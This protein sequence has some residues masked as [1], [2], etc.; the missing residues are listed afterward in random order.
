VVLGALIPF[1]VV[2]ANVVF[3]V[4]LGGELF[5]APG[6]RALVGLLAR[7]NALMGLQVALLGERLLTARMRTPERPLPGLRQSWPR[8]VGA[9]MDLE[10]ANAGVLAAAVRTD[11]RLLACVGQQVAFEMSFGDEA[12]LASIIIAAERP[13]ARLVIVRVLY[14]DSNVGLEV[15]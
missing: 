10:T 14:M 9:Y 12:L 6:K 13:F 11:M 7:V 15:A 2:P 8:Y 5:C 4:S 3:E 1:V